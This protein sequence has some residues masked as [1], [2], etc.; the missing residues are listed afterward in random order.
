M[1]GNP[2]HTKLALFQSTAGFTLLEQLIIVAMLGILS[3]IAAP[4]WNGYINRINLNAAQSQIYQAMQE[5]KSKAV[6]QKITWQFS[7]RESPISGKSVVQ[8]A[9]HPSS[10]IP[11]SAN[12]HSLAPQVQIYQQETTLYSDKKNQ[13]QRVQFNYIGN[14]N[15]QLGQITL[16][17]NHTGKTKRCVYVSTLIGAMRTGKEH[18]KPNSSGKSCY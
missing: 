6:L 15:G 13:L 5:A 10:I 12:W 1:R 7:V 14:T 11:S 3:A 18:A 17:A 16:T 8:W 2:K 9:I 4:A